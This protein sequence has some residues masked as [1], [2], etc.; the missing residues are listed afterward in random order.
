MFKSK[1]MYDIAKEE[2]L[3]GV[4]E[5][6]GPESNPRIMEYLGTTTIRATDDITPW[7]SAFVNWVAEQAGRTGTGSAASASWYNWGAELKKPVEGC[8]IGF[9]REDGSG[10]IGF[11]TGKSGD[12]WYEILG[13]NQDNRIKLSKFKITKSGESRRWYFRKPKTVLNSKAIG[14]A[15][16]G[17]VAGANEAGMITAAADYLTVKDLKELKDL[18][19]DTKAQVEELRQS[20]EVP[21][22]GFTD[23][24]DMATPWIVLAMFLYLARDRVKKMIN[25]GV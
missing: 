5:V 22:K 13:G 2:A 1:T 12:G 21:V 19:V 24:M 18:A 25:F 3:R 15:T 7:C 17:V 8:L 10:H 4:V 23:Y 16:I 9:I 6:D 14:T 11:Y 20:I